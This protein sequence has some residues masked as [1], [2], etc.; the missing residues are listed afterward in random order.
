MTRWTKALDPERYNQPRVK[1]VI[2]ALAVIFFTAGLGVSLRH[3]PE[4]LDRLDWWPVVLLM[5]VAVPVNI[6]VNAGIFILT[7]RLVGHNISFTGALEIGVIGS[8]ANMLPLP[9][10]V[11]VRVVG[12]K[13]LGASYRKGA[14]VTALVAS[15]WAGV[16]F[17]YAGAWMSAFGGGI[18]GP[19]FVVAGA[20]TTLAGLAAMT[21]FTVTWRLVVSLLGL[22]VLLVVLDA[23]RILWCL[24]AL[25]TAA[26]FAQA[27]AFSVASVVGAA[28]SIV[29]AGLG[30]REAASAAL[31]PLVDL[32]ASI[33]FLAASLNRLVGLC[34]VLPLTFALLLRNH[35]RHRTS[36]S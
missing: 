6:G 15:L 1:T 29:P 32:D 27:S 31:A 36:P 4:I 10:G 24:N 14:G 13:T 11:V 25:G 23:L 21:R 20:L 19:L 28:L 2:L 9:G 22:L 18:V 30:V 8:A 34:V 35:I 17:L 16:A 7:A 12:L 33:G 5:A 26:H 3:Q